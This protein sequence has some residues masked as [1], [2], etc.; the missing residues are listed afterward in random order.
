[1]TTW[2]KEGVRGRL[3]IPAQKGK[4]RLEKLFKSKGCD[5]YITSLEEGNHSPGSLHPIGEAFDFRYASLVSI[6][7][8]KA[9]LGP[10]WDVVAE[11]DHIHA[12]RDPKK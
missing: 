7:E 1:M 9:V 11:L 10:D 8:I 3:S 4:G 5:L 12:E 2:Y 6:K